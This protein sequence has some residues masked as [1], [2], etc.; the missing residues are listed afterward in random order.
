M[1]TSLKVLILLI[2]FVSCSN[3]KSS[4]DELTYKRDSLQDLLYKTTLDINKVNLSISD[5]DTSLDINE[6][7]IMKKIINEKT[8]IAKIEKD[9]RLLENKLYSKDNED[10]NIP[11]EIKTI[12]YELFNHYFIVFGNVEAEKYA[13]LSPEMGGRVEK[14]YVEEGER[15]EKGRLLL[16]INTDAIDKQIAGVKSSLSFATSN[17]NKQKSLW[18]QKVGSEIQFLQAKTTKEGLESQLKSLEAKKRMAQL[19][20]PFE[21]IVNKIYVK[22]SEMA[23]PQFP[24]IEFV[25]LSKMIIRANVSEKYISKVKKNQVVELLFSSIP[26]FKKQIPITRV[27]NVLNPKSRTFEVELKFNNKNEMIK[28]NM[29]STIKVN[30]F[31]TK[32]AFVIP[33][34]VIKKDISGDYVYVAVNKDSK[35]IVEK[36]QVVAGK[37]YEDKTMITQ[38]LSIGDKVIVKGYNFVSAGMPVT[39]K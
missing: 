23:G 26:E 1:K 38:G 31:S 28:P 29:V 34:L 25:N 5:I 30:D 21:G 8:K 16:K 37:S 27:S 17:Y 24:A 6:K 19:K 33:S 4:Y 20:A 15:V 35:N 36:R 22:K 3:H 7:V 13:K 2:T 9:I 10:K 12:D 39:I 18:E 14:I 11:V 32:K